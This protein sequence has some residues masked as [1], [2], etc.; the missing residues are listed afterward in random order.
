MEER[1]LSPRALGFLP[2]QI[3]P[4]LVVSR[5]L[6]LW[7]G[8]PTSVDPGREAQTACVG[9]WADL[10]L[11]ELPWASYSTSLCLVSEMIIVPASQGDC[12]SELTHVKLLEPHQGQN[13]VG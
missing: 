3:Y 11:A 6:A 12:E 4:G 5:Q 1:P 2:E 10:S 8:G 7:C 9:F 13:K